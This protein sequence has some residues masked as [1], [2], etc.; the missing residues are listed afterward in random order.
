M[1][2]PAL[3]ILLP[4]IFATIC[5]SVRNSRVVSFLGGSAALLLALVALLI[6]ID[7]AM[8]LGP[9]SFKLS[10]SLNVLGRSLTLGPGQQSML[11]LIYGLVAL[12]FFGSEAAGVARRLV[13]LGLA[14]TA[15]LVASLAVEPF[16]Y[17][18]LLIEMAVLLAIPMISPPYQAPGRGLIRFLIYQTLAMPF[19]LFAGW[20][21]PGVEASPGDLALAIQSASMLGLGFAFLL[22]IFPLYSW[23]P[24][25]SEE[26]S[27]YLI[28]FLLW[29]LPTV[30]I[31]FGMGFLDRYSWLRNAPELPSALR[32]AGL[33]MVVTGGLWAAFQRHLGRMLAYAA[34][35]ETGFYLLALSLAPQAGVILVFLLI[36]PRALTLAIWSLALSAVSSRGRSL[37]FQSV[38]GLARLYPIA[39]IGVILAYLSTVGFP[40]LAGFPVHLALWEGL[41]RQSL[42]AAVWFLVGILGLST[43]ALRTLA[44]LVMAP[45]GSRWEWKET[46]TQGILIGLGAMALFVLGLFPQEVQPLLTKLPLMFDHLGH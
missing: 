43:G 7:F 37:D 1:S 31:V 3:W 35:A 14:I 19:I 10:A 44:T 11:T 9:F 39:S 26:S 33:L 45:K 40:L 46:P 6:P 32:L 41:A 21:L 34:I 8:R 42:T 22:A 2:A 27:P 38:Q 18:A 29:I 25:I 4:L 28:G 17:A 12:W 24:M 16:L 15:L 30:T 20:L 5:L 13:P 36:V 23:I